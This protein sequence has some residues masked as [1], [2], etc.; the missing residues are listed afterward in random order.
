M[1][2]VREK[3]LKYRGKRRGRKLKIGL[4]LI[5]RR[6]FKKGFQTEAVRFEM[7]SS[8][9]KDGCEEGG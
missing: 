1:G 3:D 4:I 5:K 6:D 8:W 9:L 2:S 7:F